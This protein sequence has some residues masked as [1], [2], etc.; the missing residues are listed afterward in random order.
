MKAP[1]ALPI[2]GD[3]YLADTQHLTLEEHGAYFKLLLCAWRTQACE[4]PGDDKRLATMLGVSAG[5]WA[6]L[7]P[8]V[9][10]FWTPTSTGWEQKRLTKER[11][12]VDEKRAKNILAAEASW[13]RKPMETNKQADASASANAMPLSPTHLISKEE[14]VLKNT[15]HARDGFENFWKSYP[16]RVGK[17]AAEKA[18]AAAC[19]RSDSEAIITAA[20]RY[21]QHPPDDPKFIPH[22]ATWLNQGRYDDEEPQHGYAP[23]NQQPG[24]S[25]P[26]PSG[27]LGAVLELLAESRAA[28]ANADQSSD[29]GIAGRIGHA[30][31]QRR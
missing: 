19:K 9:M 2:F 11:R 29:Y 6:K 17:V 5:K 25:D 10:A 21:A 4:L 15:L 31:P 12:F 27:R 26:P 18:W 23:Q 14:R 1:A 24:R 3:A 16:R 20:S 8:A 30:V 7:K 22:P 13:P 28:A